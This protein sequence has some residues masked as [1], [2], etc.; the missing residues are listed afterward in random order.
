MANDYLD[1]LAHHG[2]LGQKWG[3]RRYQPYSTTGPRKGGKTG[4]EVGKAKK[5]KSRKEDVSSLSDQELRTKINRMQMEQ[6]YKN[7]KGSKRRKGANMAIKVLEIAGST[8]GIVGGVLS[9]RAVVKN[10]KLDNSNKAAA[11]ANKVENAVNKGKNA[12]RA[13]GG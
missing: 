1:F 3:V 9:V 10:D 7:L 12:V 8:I 11:V 13:I 6:Q 2:I 4:K 5:V